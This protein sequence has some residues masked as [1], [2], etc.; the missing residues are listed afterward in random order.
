[1]NLKGVYIFKQA[2]KEIARSNNIITSNGKEAILQFLSGSLSEWASSLAVGVMANNSPTV[3][4]LALEYEIARSAITLKS[5]RTGSPDIL[6]LKGTIDASVSANIYEIGIF[7]ITTSQV[8]GK[9]DALVITD[10]SRPIDWLVTAGSYSTIAFASQ[11][12][13]SPR[14]GL[15]SM[16]LT[17]ATTITNPGVYANLSSYT[18]LDTLDILVNVPSGKSGDLEITLTDVN[19]NSIVMTY[20]FSTEG[21][22]VLSQNFP[23]NIMSLS[24]I[25]SI[26]IKTI[27]ASSNIV[28]DAIKVSV[29]GEISKSSSLISRSTLAT[30]IGKIYGTPLDV[31][32]YVQMS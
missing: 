31:E 18:K 20:P 7:P 30:P 14:V 16:S 5:Y 6:I 1:M 15:N 13:I 24:S 26:Q 19:S 9:K 8:F 29:L 21:Y 3:S 11:S 17:N 23:T 10:F 32:Y 27:G 28:L 12:S 22:Q 4:D 2:G 25:E